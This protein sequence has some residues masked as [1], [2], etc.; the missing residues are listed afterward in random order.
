[1]FGQYFRE[2]REQAHLTQEELVTRMRR[3]G[4]FITLAR[5]KLIEK[6]QAE[7]FLADAV[8]MCTVLPASIYELLGYPDV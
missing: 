2:L 1:M 6:N 3:E 8:A 4:C 7:P 5:Y